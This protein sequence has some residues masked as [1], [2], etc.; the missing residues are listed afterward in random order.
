MTGKRK[1]FP[2]VE[3]HFKVLPSSEEKFTELYI[4]V[5]K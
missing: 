3:R 2:S 5:N 1:V 4:I